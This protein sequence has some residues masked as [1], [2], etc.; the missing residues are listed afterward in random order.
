MR[1]WWFGDDFVLPQGVD[2][3]FDM[4][5]REHLKNVYRFLGEEPPEFLD[6]PIV[7]KQVLWTKEE[8][9][10]AMEPGQLLRIMSDAPGMVRWSLDRWKTSAT[11]ALEPAGDVMANL[12]G[13][14]TTLGPFD[15]GT[16][17]V[18]FIFEAEKAPGTHTVIIVRPCGDGQ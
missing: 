11:R 1:F 16:W 6:E 9:V 14:S 2:W 18:E 7:R 12:S 10:R 15:E 8:P 13:Y 3:M 17:G 5:F 4:L